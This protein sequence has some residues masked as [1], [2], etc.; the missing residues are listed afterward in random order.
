MDEDRNWQDTGEMVH[1]RYV[2]TVV[3]NG[4]KI[5]VADGPVPEGIPVE[6][7]VKGDTQVKAIYADGHVDDEPCPVL[8]D[9][10]PSALGRRGLLSEDAPRGEG[11]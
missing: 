6:L 3:E 11:A 10:G 9:H 8:D 5:F 1:V 4:I 2:P 7:H